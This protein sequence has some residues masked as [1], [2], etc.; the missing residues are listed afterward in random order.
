MVVIL[1]F[2]CVTSFY[3]ENKTKK[4]KEQIFTVEIG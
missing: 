3:A 2:F 4:D 1:I